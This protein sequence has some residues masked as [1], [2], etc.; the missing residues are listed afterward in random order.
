MLLPAL[1]PTT[2][3]SLNPP[4]VNIGEIINKG[5]ELTLNTVNTTGKVSWRTSMNYSNNKNNVVSLGSSGKLIGII[6]RLPVTRTEE[7]FPISYF[8][9]YQTDGIFQTQAEV[10]EYA[11]NSDGTR[12]GDIKFKDLNGD[13]VI[14]ELDQTFLGSPLPDFTLNVTNNIEYKGFDFNIFFQGVYG[15]KILNLMRRDI[16]G[17]AGLANQ[18]KRMANRSKPGMPSPDL[19]R[20]TG[21]DPNDNRRISDRY[22]EDGSFIRLKN[23]TLGYS[24]DKSVL[25][26]AKVKNL[27]V[28]FSTQ[29]LKT[30]SKYSGY[31]PEVG[32][33]NQNPLINGVENGRYPISI[34]YTF[35]L[36]VV[37]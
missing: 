1:L 20:T 7:G 32:S 24:F 19:P 6:Q 33:Y 3:G 23:M 13:N 18:T 15:N 26:R 22:I 16:E 37:F 2:A 25:Q 11:F 31:D 5:L 28:Y 14:N 36:N 4:F 21:T 10:D 27:R 9:G 8:Y 34:S 30:W 17:L 12:V 29:N 35:G